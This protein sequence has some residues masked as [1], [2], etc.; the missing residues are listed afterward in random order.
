[1]LVLKRHYQFW[2]CHSWRCTRLGAIAI[3][4]TNQL[5]QKDFSYRFDGGGRVGDPVHGGR[6][7]GGAGRARGAG[8]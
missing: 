5:Q 6:W 8:M 7:Y 1:M 2:L 4:A 3:P